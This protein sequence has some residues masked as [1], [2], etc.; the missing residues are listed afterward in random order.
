MSIMFKLDHGLRYVKLLNRQQNKNQKLNKFMLCI[1]WYWKGIIY[2]K[3]LSFCKMIDSD[4]YCYQLI[5]LKQAIEKARP[6]LI[7][8]KTIVFKQDNARP[9]IS[10]KTRLRLN[11]FGWQVMMYTPY[12]SDMVQ[13]NYH[14]FRSL[15][16][17]MFSSMQESDEYLVQFLFPPNK[18]VQILRHIA[19]YYSYKY[20]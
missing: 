11:D 17:M 16:R 3:N 12:I 6:N 19:L 5:K 4:L 20:F 14:L 10:V 13:C 9:Y 2:Y 1:W 8:W 18:V 15:K 7:N